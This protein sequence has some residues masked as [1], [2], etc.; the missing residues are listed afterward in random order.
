[1]VLTPQQRAMNRAKKAL[2]AGDGS[3]K[4]RGAANKAT[5]EKMKKA[6]DEQTRTIN[7]H[8][9]READRVIAELSS[10]VNLL[11][12]GESSD[13]Q[14]RTNARLM[15]NAANNKANKIDREVRQAEAAP[16][17]Q[18]SESESGASDEPMPEAEPSTIAQA[19]AANSDNAAEP[20]RKRKRYGNESESREKPSQLPELG[21]ASPISLAVAPKLQ[22]KSDE[23]CGWIDG[24]GAPC[25]NMLDE[26]EEHAEAWVFQKQ[27]AE[28]RVLRMKEEC[29][30]ASRKQREEIA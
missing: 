19:P 13:P 23:E 12:G 24:D 21:C 3:F 5:F 6:L 2:E 29:E 20:Q 25:P 22:K 18:D 30:E 1:M 17:P 11:G 15:P 9:T 8:S 4:P 10:R 27:C 26:C 7:S 16:P 28:G 14:E